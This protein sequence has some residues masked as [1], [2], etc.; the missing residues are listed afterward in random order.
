MMEVLELNQVSPPAEVDVLPAPIKKLMVVF[1]ITISAS[2][3]YAPPPPPPPTPWSVLV[4]PL[5]PPPQASTVILVTFA[6]TVHGED[7][8]VVRM[9]SVVC[10]K[11]TK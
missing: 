8:A 6:G 4:P 10:A 1:G 3:E 2:E 9:T 5:P 7:D 11:A